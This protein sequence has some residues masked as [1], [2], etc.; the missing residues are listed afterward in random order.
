MN[1]KN[2]NPL[3]RAVKKKLLADLLKQYLDGCTDEADVSAKKG[4][5]QFPNLA[6]FCRMLGCGPQAFLQLA[7]AYPAH[8]DWLI[9][10]FED[11]VLRHEPSPTVLTAYLK[12]RL[13]YADKTKT[14][15]AEADCGLMRLVFEHDITEDGE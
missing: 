3:I 13:G 10:V 8:A 9:A 12:R 6:G 1:K 5:R 4:A 14:E 2:N 15:E 7:E 11:E